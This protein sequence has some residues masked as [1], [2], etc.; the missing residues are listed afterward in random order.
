[1]GMP[2]STNTERRCSIKVLILLIKAL[3]RI[4]FGPA[5]RRSQGP[6]EPPKAPAIFK[7]S[8]HT[9]HCCLKG[10]ETSGD[11]AKVE[12]PD[13]LQDLVENS[14][15]GAAIRLSCMSPGTIVVEGRTRVV[16]ENGSRVPRLEL[17][18]HHWDCGD[19]VTVLHDAEEP[20]KSD[21]QDY[22]TLAYEPLAWDALLARFLWSISACGLD[23]SRT[24]SSLWYGKTRRRMWPGQWHP[25]K[26]AWK[27]RS[28]N[29]L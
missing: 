12:R 20:V 19:R 10:G 16:A 24:G 11:A 18:I 7:D 9:L 4:L 21:A 15:L 6:K 8:L 3:L 27:N 14:R 29:H 22:Y 17:L 1:M 26:M 5:I 2:K 23:H 25:K 13:N 28:H